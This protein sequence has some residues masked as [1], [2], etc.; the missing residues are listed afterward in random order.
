MILTR[1]IAQSNRFAEACRA[2]F[3]NGLRIVISPLLRIVPRATQ[4]DLD[5]I[6][7]LV[8]TSANG[9]AAFA[10]QSDD[11]NL[12]AWCVGDRTAEAARQVGFQAVSADGDRHALVALLAAHA[13]V[14]RLLHLRGVKT[15]GN[16]AQD[17]A[18]QG[19]ETATHVIYDQAPLAFSEAA[20][21]LLSGSAPVIVPLFSPRTATL[22]APVLGRANAPLCI[23]AMSPAVAATIQVQSNVRVEVAVEP[24]S[25]A[26]LDAI[27]TLRGSSRLERGVGPG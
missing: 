21:H 25:A 17:L 23:A 2:R 22:A 15:A 9:V 16:L 14:G 12:P 4:P 10:S 26:M 6:S 3:G 5:G 1:P 7:G 24:R 11:R 20:T 19:I 13:P 8:F 27:A 18:K